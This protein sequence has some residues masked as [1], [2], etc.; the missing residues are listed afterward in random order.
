MDVL[1]DGFRMGDF[2]GRSED[3]RAAWERDFSPR[4]FTQLEEVQKRSQDFIARIKSVVP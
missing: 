2:L 3:L 1:Q 4:I